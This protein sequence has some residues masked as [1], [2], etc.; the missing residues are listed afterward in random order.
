VVLN[1]AGTTGLSAATASNDDPLVLADFSQ[2]LIVD[3]MG[4]EVVTA[5]VYGANG[6][7]AGQTQFVAFWRVGADLLVGD[8]GR[9]LRVQLWRQGACRSTSADHS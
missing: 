2:Y 3:R 1:A 7:L 8:A 4:T 9:L 5:P 6:R